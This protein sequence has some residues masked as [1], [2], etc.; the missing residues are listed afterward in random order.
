MRKADYFD[1]LKTQKWFKLNKEYDFKDSG[2]TNT[3]PWTPAPF[4]YT[5]RVY[6]YT[7]TL[8]QFIYI[9]KNHLQP[10][11]VGF[12]AQH[13]RHMHLLDWLYTIFHIIFRFY[14]ELTGRDEMG[15]DSDISDGVTKFTLCDNWNDS[16]WNTAVWNGLEYRNGT[17]LW[18]N[19]CK[20]VKRYMFETNRI[21]FIAFPWI[22]YD[23][24]MDLKV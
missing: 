4:S 1:N 10:N 12:S 8:S 14:T 23:W 24:F 21:S 5:N 16:N 20:V 19:K 9:P 17:I 18:H 15:K 6:Q 3:P 2:L 22:S 7:H 11:P 13:T